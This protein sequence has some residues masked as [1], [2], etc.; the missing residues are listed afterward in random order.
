MALKCLDFQQRDGP[1]VLERKTKGR[2]RC[3]GG[4]SGVGETRTD[5]P[6]HRYTVKQKQMLTGYLATYKYAR[7]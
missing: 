2:W 1:P 5:G 4:G 3:G 7:K 6:S